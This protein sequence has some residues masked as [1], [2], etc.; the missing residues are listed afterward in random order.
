MLESQNKEAPKSVYQ[1]D[2]QTRC[3]CWKGLEYKYCGCRAESMAE[4]E[5]V[6]NIILKK[7]NKLDIHISEVMEDKDFIQDVYKEL[8]DLCRVK[9]VNGR[10]IKENTGPIVDKKK[11]S[12]A[13]EDD[14]EQKEVK[15]AFL[16]K[17]R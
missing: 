11:P 2:Q 5:Q 13:I 4:I 16:I 8:D 15:A 10:V 7:K 9:I 3:D 1:P 12:L 6:I 17:R 14:D